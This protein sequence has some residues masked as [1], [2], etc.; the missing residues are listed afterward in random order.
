MRK[1]ARA[2]ID[3]VVWSGDGDVEALFDRAVLVRRTRRWRVLRPARARGQRL[4]QGARS[5]RSQRGGVLTQGGL[6][7][8]LAKPNQTSP[9]HRG[10][11]VRERLLCQTLP[12][13]PPTSRS[14]RPSS[15]RS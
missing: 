13:P 4:R 1:E 3:D 8:L 2:F 7:S 6:M 10:K 14:C 15:S 11:F 9:V 12:P 5:T